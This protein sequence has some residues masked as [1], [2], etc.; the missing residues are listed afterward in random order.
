MRQLFIYGTLRHLQLLEL[1]LGRPAGA[2]DLSEASLPG[3]RVSAAVEGP[4]PTI[5]VCE[6][7]QAEGLLV[8]GLSAD[9]FARL[10]FYEG[11]FDYDLVPVTLAEGQAAEVYLPQP[12]RWTA[13][14]PWSLAQWEADWA[15][16]SCHAARE[17]MSY[18]GKRPRAEVDAMFPMIRRRAH[19]QVLA[20]QGAHDPLTLNGKIKVTDRS[21]VY[22]KFFALD[23]IS[24]R[25]ETFDGGIS[26][27]IDR[28]VFI[29]ADAALVLPY[30][31]L[32]DR[33]LL[34]EQIR[35]GPLARGDHTCW[36]L[37]PI[38]GHIDPGETP[39][40][41]ARREA[42]EE[43]GITLSVLES[44]G[45]VYASPGNATEFFHIFVGLAD[46]PDHIIGTGGL[47]A[48]GE[49]IRS[50]LMSFDDLMAL[51]D[52]QALANAPLVASAYWL[53]RH[54]ER[55]RSEGTTAKPDGT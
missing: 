54:R 51:A 4:F 5:E 33:V 12:G 22:A 30:D 25:H 17:V 55:L 28:A 32:R 53:A 34:V 9:D 26:P 48:E 42:Q 18:M 40:A 7:A 27:Q 46:L 14:G 21:R 24:L 23:E 20:E 13:Q 52:A 44:V 10:D 47:A 2:I 31:P 37:E 15:A 19:Q 49:D 41:A 8:Q 35:M 3:Y 38:A 11:A 29:G 45:N 39:Q 36:Q 1:V 50:H 16:L 6:G 43:A